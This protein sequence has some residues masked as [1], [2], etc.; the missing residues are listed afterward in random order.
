TH[1]SLCDMP[2]MRPCSPGSIDIETREPTV[3]F[4][5][6]FTP[7][8]LRRV[9]PGKQAPLDLFAFVE[10]IYDLQHYFA[11]FQSHSGNA[12]P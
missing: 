8:R 12:R 5:V 2:P 1:Q 4:A 3:A 9:A 10:A 6:N 7:G 11:I